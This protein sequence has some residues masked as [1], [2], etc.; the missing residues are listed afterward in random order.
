MPYT[1]QWLR[2]FRHEI[3][4]ATHYAMTLTFG[5]KTAQLEIVSSGHLGEGGSG[6]KGRS[7]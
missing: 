7:A 1:N 3:G 4:R 6:E 5:G 2:F